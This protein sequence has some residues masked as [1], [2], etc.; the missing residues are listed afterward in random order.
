MG[1]STSQQPE[2]KLQLTS[3]PSNW[4]VLPN[5]RLGLSLPIHPTGKHTYLATDGTSRLCM[6][7]EKRSRI[8][9]MI[10]GAR[11]RCSC[12][13][14]NLDGLASRQYEPP[15]G[16]RSPRY[17]DVLVEKGTEV[18]LPGGRVGRHMSHSAVLH[19]C[20]LVMLPCGNIRCVHGHSEAT[21]RSRSRVGLKTR[22][23]LCDC[24]I[25]KSSWRRRSYQNV[26]PK[27]VAA[28]TTPESMSRCVY[29]L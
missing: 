3:A 4:T 1:E 16:W 12:D 22:M 18:H 13:C 23:R 7:G 2:A 11:K 10:S 26:K 19:G 24:T 29:E 15:R 27:Y 21:L 5:G 6:H 8:A 20:N 9:M 17:Y 25:G 28:Y 14:Q